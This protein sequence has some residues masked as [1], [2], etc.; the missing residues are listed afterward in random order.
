MAAPTK[1]WAALDAIATNQSREAIEY[2]LMEAGA[3]GTETTVAPDD[4]FNVRG[5]FDT[6]PDIEL[7]RAEL[8]QALKIHGQFTSSSLSLKTSEVADRDWLAEWKKSWQPVKVGRFIIAPPWIESLPLT[9]A[10]G[11]DGPPIIIRINPG[12]AFGTGTHETTRLCLK[13]IEK[14]FQGGSFLDVGTGTGILAIAAVKISPDARIEACDLDAEA[15]EIAK[16]NA[17]LNDIADRID[18]RV[19]SVNDETESADL[20]CANLTAPVIVELLPALLGATCGRL[21]LSGILDSQ[22]EM[23]KSRLIELAVVDFEVDQDGEWAA[24]VI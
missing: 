8:I 3:L 1:S 4:C 7:V 21:V 20:I 15:I 9:S 5:Y 19:G 12:M 22:I 10:S 2:G 13:A 24:L 23:V 17:R 18:F 11:S 14:Y 16:D 6:P